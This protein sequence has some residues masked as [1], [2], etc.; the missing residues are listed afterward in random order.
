[1]KGSTIA[2][3]GVFIA[4]G[5]TSVMAQQSLTAVEIKTLIIGNTLTGYTERGLNVDVYYGPDGTMSGRVQGG[6]GNHYY[7]GGRWNLADD[8]KMCRQWTTWRDGKMDC[9]RY[10]RVGDDQVRSKAIDQDYT[11]DFQVRKGDVLRMKG[12]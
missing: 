5:V 4:M 2:A 7:D 3:L 8:G 1:M 6:D 10:Y 9:F 11:F 12:Q